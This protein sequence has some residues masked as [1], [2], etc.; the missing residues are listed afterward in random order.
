MEAETRVDKLQPR[1]DP[2]WRMRLG[3]GLAM[4]WAGRQALAHLGNSQPHPTAL[5][6]KTVQPAGLSESPGT[7]RVSLPAP[8]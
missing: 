2:H 8:L 3:G 1:R 7:V 6:R 4:S 5:R